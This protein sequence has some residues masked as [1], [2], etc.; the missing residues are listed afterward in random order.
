MGGPGGGRW[1]CHVKAPVVDDCTVLNLIELTRADNFR[2]GL[3]GVFELFGAIEPEVSVEYEFA[4]QEGLCLVLKYRPIVCRDEIRLL[5]RLDI[6]L[7]HFGGH[8]WWGRCPL[9]RD[10]GSCNRLV[11]KLY[12]PLYE[13]HFG[14]RHCYGLT[15]RSAQARSTRTERREKELHQE[16]IDHLCRPPAGSRDSR[17]GD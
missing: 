7:P 12:L 11:S 9:S 8:R 16:L 4:K 1:Q 14:C 15:Y 10:G 2:A 13:R 17:P 6:T 3:G 5:V